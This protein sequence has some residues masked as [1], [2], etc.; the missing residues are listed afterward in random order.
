MQNKISSKDI[1]VVVQGDI[2]SRYIKK[3]LNSIRQYLPE[4]EIVLS[5]SKE[6][7][8]KI[9]G[10]SY[11]RLVL[12][13][14]PGAVKLNK[15]SD[16]LNNINRQ[17]IGTKEGLLQTTRLYVLKF[18]TNMCLTGNTF[19]RLYENLVDNAV[20]FNYKILALDYYTRNPRVVPLPFY[21][22]DWILFGRA[23]D[24]KK[25]YNSVDFQDLIECLWYE[26]HE[27]LSP[28]FPQVLA[29]YTPEQ[30]IFLSWLAKEEQVKISE[31]YDNNKENIDMTERII[32]Q[33]FIILDL[34]S[35]DMQFLK[36]N[37]NRYYESITLLT[38]KDWKI[39]NKKYAGLSEISS[40]EWNFYRL[41]CYFR[42]LIFFY[43]RGSM[44]WLVNRLGFRT[45]IKRFIEK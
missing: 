38:F 37:P 3:C 32:G 39:I 42:Y 29:R 22:S 12:V 23:E 40:I 30:H 45:W 9:D 33:N 34:L 20:Y 35:S 14:D 4:A 2:D 5:I 13:D 15:E 43:I 26:N 10:L 11:D 44:C 36:Y 6:E 16:K 19:L 17:I 7:E 1:S 28:I 41:K 25:Y 24:V 18:R 21:L 31:Y 8:V 27:N